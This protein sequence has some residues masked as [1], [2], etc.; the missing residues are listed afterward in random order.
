MEKHNVSRP[1]TLGVGIILL[2]SQ[3]S[4][5]GLDSLIGVCTSSEAIADVVED[6]EDHP[7]ICITLRIIH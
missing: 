5:L 7:L 2:G 4:S 6:G 3:A 1:K